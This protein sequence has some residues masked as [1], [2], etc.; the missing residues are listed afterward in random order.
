[1]AE[2]L[3]PSP[4]SVWYEPDCRML[5]IPT[6]SQFESLPR[7]K[8][9]NHAPSAF[10]ESFTQAKHKV[11]LNPDGCLRISACAALIINSSYFPPRIL[12]GQ[13][14]TGHPKMPGLMSVPGGA[15]DGNDSSLLAA[16][17]RELFEEIAH[18]PSD[19]T[20][21]V[22][23][24]S[25]VPEVKLGIQAAE[26]HLH[27]FA[28]YKGYQLS[29]R[30]GLD[31]EMLT[32]KHT[33]LVFI[34]PAL[35][36]HAEKPFYAGVFPENDSLEICLYLQA[37]LRLTPARLWVDSELLPNGVAR[38]MPVRA[39]SCNATLPETVTPKTRYFFEVFKELVA[40]G[41]IA[42]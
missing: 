18:S 3:L 35:G 21:D 34:N 32:V 33:G 28:K 8:A 23:H 16:C 37:D 24:T 29:R 17:V 10:P 12:L 39:I 40:S 13:F 26:P 25:L 1:M 19:R 41:V 15:V 5:C 7:D 14:D 2:Y 42:S 20:L 4:G 22:F 6:L 30:F 31:V 38:N 9:F 11:C 27:A 36:V